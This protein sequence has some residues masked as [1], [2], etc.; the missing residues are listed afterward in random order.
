MG[1]DRLHG[2]EDAPYTTH[3]AVQFSFQFI[4]FM[5][6]FLWFLLD[7]VNMHMRRTLLLKILGT[8]QALFIERIVYLSGYIQCK[9]Q[10]CLFE[11]LVKI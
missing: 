2:S 11:T 10:R 1:S 6:K 7:F 5:S 3:A 4:T 9:V 8:P